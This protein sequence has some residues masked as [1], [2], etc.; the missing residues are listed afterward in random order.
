[1]IAVDTVAGDTIV[2]RDSYNY[3]VQEGQTVKEVFE[4]WQN[5]RPYRKSL[6]NVKIFKLVDITEE[7]KV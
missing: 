4:E 3:T 1:M 6:N 5:D 2:D 7:V